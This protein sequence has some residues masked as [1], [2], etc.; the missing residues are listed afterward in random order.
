MCW[1]ICVTFAANRFTSTLIFRHT[2]LLPTSDR[3]DFPIQ[4]CI[5]MHPMGASHLVNMHFRWLLWLCSEECVCVRLCLD[6]WRTF[7]GNMRLI[8]LNRNKLL[9]Y[10]MC[11]CF[12]ASPHIHIYTAGFELMCSTRA[13]RSAGKNL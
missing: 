8:L 2:K 6:R 5:G 9:A 10:I 1:W 3:I 12:A 13:V 7:R 4:C 11:L